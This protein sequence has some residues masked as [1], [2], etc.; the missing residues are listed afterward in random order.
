MVGKTESKWRTFSFSIKFEPQF[1]FMKFILHFILLSISA[2]LT[3]QCDGNRYLNFIFPETESTTDI[4]YGENINYQGTSESLYMDVYE[5]AGDIEDGRPLIIMCHGGYFLSGDKAGPDMLPLCTDLA[6]M[7]YVVASINYRKGIPFGAS[8]EVPYGQA[9]VR[10]VQDLRAAIRWF[11]KNAE[12]EG[13]SYGINTNQIF[14]GGASAGAFMALHLAY[15]DENEIP[16]WL[17]MT[18]P[19]LEGG[20]EGESGN[21]GYSSDIMGILPV[22]GALGDSDWIDADDTT[23][24]CMFHGDADATVT[25]DS[26]TFVLFGLINVTTIEGSNY[27]ADRMEDVGIDHCYHVTPGGGHVPYLGNAVEYDYTLSLM[28]GFMHGMVCNEMFDCSYHEILSGTHEIAEQQEGFVYPNPAN[29]IFFLK[30]VDNRVCSKLYTL[31]GRKI[32]DI[33]GSQFNASSLSEGIYVIE[34]I[35]S[36]GSQ[37]RE[38]IVIAH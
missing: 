37:M 8:L 35:G 27:I 15:M 30:G 2:Q 38:R 4:Q 32:T 3:A 24:A 23:P 22:S 36:N 19:G 9:V 25:I 17:N 12:E 31:D 18:I 5:P 29:D 1:T 6:K 26:A 34:K 28:S 11:R 10:A 16:S 33:T 13:N 7:G 21:P 20:L 14:V